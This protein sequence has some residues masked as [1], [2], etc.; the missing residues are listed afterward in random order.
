MT[1]FVR[2]D[3]REDELRDWCAERLAS[4]KV[5]KRIVRVDDFP[6]TGTGKIQ[7]HL[8]RDAH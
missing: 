4:F 3:A 1:A 6:R 5:P 7:K 8:L 2:G